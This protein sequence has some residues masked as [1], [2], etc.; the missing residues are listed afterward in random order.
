M[1][2]TRDLVRNEMMEGPDY[3]VTTKR[4]QLAVSKM[5]PE[6]AL[7]NYR[8]TRG[9]IASAAQVIPRLNWDTGYIFRH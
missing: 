3:W 6:A 2:I 5:K 9:T 1:V 8:Y 4:S 7:C